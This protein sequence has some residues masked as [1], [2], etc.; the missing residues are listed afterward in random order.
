MAFMGLSFYASAQDIEVGAVPPTPTASS[1]VKYGDIPVKLFVGAPDI[2]IPLYQ[3]E[4][5]DLSVPI[6][7]NYLAT[8]IKVEE[9]AS[10]TGLGWSLS[11][12]GSVTRSVR[13][14]PDEK[15]VFGY[16]AQANQLETI[17]NKAKSTWTGTDM[18]I[19]GEFAKGRRDSSPDVFYYSFPGGSGQFVFDKN[20]QPFTI[21]FAKIKIEK[22][23]GSTGIES[24][25]ITHTDGTKLYFGKA[26]GRSAIDQTTTTYECIGDDGIS[27]TA[28]NTSWHLLKM[29]S[30]TGDVVE[31]FYDQAYSLSYDN[32]N[33]SASIVYQYSPGGRQWRSNRYCFSTYSMSGKHLTKIQ[34]RSTIVDFISSANR[35]DISGD[36][37]LDQVLV[38]SRVSGDLIKGYNLSFS[39]YNPSGTM[40]EK[41]LKLDKV[42]EIGRNGA[43]KNPY[44]FQYNASYNLPSRN[45]KAQ[46][47]WGY[48]NGQLSNNASVVGMVPKTISGRIFNGG[49]DRSTHAE[50]LKAGILEKITY[51]AKGSTQ[52][53]YEPHMATK[54]P[55]EIT[56]G[57]C[58]T[59]PYCNVVSYSV[60][61]N[62]DPR[63][64]V[65]CKNETLSFTMPDKIIDN[66]KIT[67]NFSTVA[68]PSEI[69]RY[70]CDA[71]VSLTDSQ[72]NQVPMGELGSGTPATLPLRCT[73]YGSPYNYGKTFTAN[74]KAG[75][76][77]TIS[78]FKGLEGVRSNLSVSFY[79][80]TNP[81]E[82]QPILGP[83][84]G[85]RIKRITHHD[86]VSEANNMVKEY[87]YPAGQLV[88]KYEYLSDYIDSQ[89]KGYETGSSQS[90]IAL[91]SVQGSHICYTTVT[92]L[93]G[94]NG[95][96][97]K[98]VHKFS[99][100]ADVNYP[101]MRS[102]PFVPRI[103]SDWKRGLPLE[104]SIYDAN[105]NHLHKT[106][107]TP[108]LTEG[109]NKSV[110]T[111]YVVG[112]GALQAHAP[113]PMQEPIRYD[114]AT[115]KYTSQWVYQSRV[116][117]ESYESG[118][119]ANAVRSQVDFVYGNATHAQLTSK[120][121]N[122]YGKILTTKYKYPADF[123]NTGILGNMQNLHIMDQIIEKY[124]LV[125]NAVVFAS[126][127]QF[128]NQNQK[129]LLQGEFEG[130]FEEPVAENAF[131]S[132]YY[133]LQNSYEYDDNG[134]LESATGPDQ[135][136]VSFIWGYDST[137]PI[138]KAVGV[139]H[140]VL[141]IAYNSVSGN[142]SLLRD[143]ADLADAYIT[144][145]TYDPL[146]GVT[147]MTDENSQVTTYRYDDLGHLDHIRD[148]D[149]NILEK[150][151]YH[152]RD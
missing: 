19:L 12:G 123:S 125:N 50:Y 3:A 140:E 110:L 135:V 62:C 151:E 100:A 8:G 117:K 14:I 139:T 146:L 148:N 145:Y 69:P 5:R 55:D 60:K 58:S 6:A 54:S 112:D 37:R 15:A 107:F 152:F 121:E 13:G 102:L 97:G 64:N 44:T 83:V 4:G 119:V 91:G 96:N 16:F 134:N 40:E 129:I 111:W 90:N 128:I 31:F 30:T 66:L 61:T 45:S 18:T 10:L 9:V 79:E 116:V 127:N 74:L 95:T 114:I 143:H 142:L 136:P 120:T 149:G 1:M 73:S 70:E 94:Q 28:A 39:Y 88:T 25:V 65:A 137:L 53:E 93:N 52:F 84:G 81:P 43:A 22:A 77:Y 7:L 130:S 27:T 51:P 144:T 150:F 21:P 33:A 46:D 147:S 141:S 113:A 24:F 20:Q 118:N 56:P 41:R 67:V 115:L 72:G 86:G 85:L 82:P 49:G 98:T 35:E 48:F 109:R 76:T 23:T 59:N 80:Y 89:G 75:Q 101:S 68:I 63:T 133:E 47:H 103:S 71:Y 78:A 34:S 106:V 11:A 126:Q 105:N 99:Y 122:V 57:D 138:V 2:S 87:V 104:T 36:R 32:E 124:E 92:E 38:K 17:A 131:N 29:V 132:S 26:D 108:N 42:T